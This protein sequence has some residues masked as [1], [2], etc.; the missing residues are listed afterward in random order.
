MGRNSTLRKAAN[1]THTAVKDC[2]GELVEAYEKGNTL[3]KHA[4]E[5]QE[6]TFN[7]VEAENTQLRS[8]VQDLQARASAKDEEI[9][10]LQGETKKK[11]RT[12]AQLRAQALVEEQ[13]SST[14]H[15][16]LE[17][18][19]LQRTLV[20]AQDENT[21]LRN[22]IE[23]LE[24]LQANKLQ[25]LSILANEKQSTKSIQMPRAKDLQ[26]EQSSFRTIPPGRENAGMFQERFSR[27]ILSEGKVYEERKF[28][29]EFA[30]HVNGTIMADTLKM[31]G[32]TYAR[33]Q[34]D[35]KD[36]F[37]SIV[38]P[39]SIVEHEGEMYMKR[40]LRVEVEEDDEDVL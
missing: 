36:K 30:L 35:G 8:N 27:K 6:T 38:A 31:D 17:M 4:I 16:S 7:A 10:R 39:E 32:V 3:L 40:I 2:L 5:E 14:S 26:Y 22:R 19:T 34:K 9:V 15:N 29:H 33:Y 20:D 1:S 28:L 13:K 21:R 37:V 18:A 12:I 25:K 23:A 11:D 24:K